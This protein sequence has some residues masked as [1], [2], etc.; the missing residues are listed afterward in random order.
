MGYKPMV[1][2]TPRS[3]P[4]DR[5]LIDSRRDKPQGT[6]GR[7]IKVPQAAL[8]ARV[9][10]PLGA[11]GLFEPAYVR[12]GEARSRLYAMLVLYRSLAKALGLWG[13]YLRTWVHID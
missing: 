8:S 13:Q 6:Y 9:S 1:F 3:R 10:N 12:R 5:E 11:V 7:G 4:F 2:G